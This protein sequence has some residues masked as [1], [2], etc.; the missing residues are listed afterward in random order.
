MHQAFIR[1]IATISL[2]FLPFAEPAANAQ[3]WVQF[4]GPNGQGRS[5]ATGV[6]VAWS[7]TSGIAWKTAVPGLGWSSPIILGDSIWITSASKDGKS[8]RAIA[9]DGGSG[10]IDHDVE[11]FQP[12]EPVPRNPKNSWASPSAAVEEGRV[13]VHF[14]AMGTA[15]L[16]AATARILWRNQELVIDH[17]EGPGSSPI[18]FE[19]LLI[20]NCDG[21]DHQYVAALHKSTGKI[22]WK[23]KRSAPLRSN[24][25]YRKAYSTPAIVETSSGPQLVSTGA[26]QVNAYNPRTGE[27]IWRVRYVGF[28]NVP[29][30]LVDGDRVYVVTDFPQAQ[31][32][33]LRTDGRGDVT[34]T[35]VRWKQPRQIGSSPSPILA[36]GRIYVV[37][38]QGVASCINPANGKIV[39]QHRLGGSFSASPIF[40]DG[41]LYFCNE[42][43][44]TTVVVP[45]DVYREKAAST[46]PGRILATPAVL[47]QTLILRTDTQL[48]RL[49]AGAAKP[50]ARTST[51]N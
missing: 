21:Q 12:S 16:D 50:V 34:D 23:T 48:Y 22:A 47:G 1:H 35:H 42:Q 36:D 33:A 14:G 5:S 26:D 7:A 39:W 6:P 40:V 31:L 51:A 4:R 20:V 38:D 10:R 25:D 2:I 29:V 15:C 24:P 17:K 28:S 19:N 37:T 32:W 49:E 11:V 44:K 8:L 3:G 46:L 43:G 9:V 30:P 45:G 41:H 18:L 13:Y 27:E